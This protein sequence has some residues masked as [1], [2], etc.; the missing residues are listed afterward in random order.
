METDITAQ[1]WS[2]YRKALRKALWARNRANRSVT[3][4]SVAEQRLADI[5]A[6][7]GLPTTLWSQD[8]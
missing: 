5:A 2:E 7:I 3:D 6:K 4:Y 1:D 8:W